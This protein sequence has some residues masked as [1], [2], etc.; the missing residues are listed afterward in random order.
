MKILIPFLAAILISSC[1]SSMHGSFKD[2]MSASEKQHLIDSFKTEALNN[3]FFDTIGVDHSGLEIVS[4]Q[5]I[6]PAGSLYK[7]ISITVKNVSGKPVEA[8]RL[9][10]YGLTAFGEP[11]DF[12]L[13]QPGFG[14]GQDDHFLDVGKQETYTWTYAS[15]N[16]KHIVK[17]WP[18]EVVFKDGTKWKSSVNEK[19]L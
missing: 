18:R 17:A 2:E 19:K 7:D 16:V 3:A 1:D 10:W 15:K 12:D 14:G 11:A 4:V 6:E 8:F 5:I 13:M 9:K